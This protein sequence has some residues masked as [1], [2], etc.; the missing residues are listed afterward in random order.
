M[1]GQY[2]QTY[3]ENQDQCLRAVFEKSMVRAGNPL[4]VPAHKTRVE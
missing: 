2:S 4:I 1:D 3:G